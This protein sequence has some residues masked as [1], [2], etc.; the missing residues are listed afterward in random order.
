[1]GGSDDN[2][3]G[4][5]GAGWFVTAACAGAAG[6]STTSRTGSA[7]VGIGGAV[8]IAGSGIFGST[9]G[10]TVATV[11]AGA[12]STLVFGGFLTTGRGGV[13]R[14]RG[15]WTGRVGRARGGRPRRSWT[16]RHVVARLPRM[17]GMVVVIVSQLH[18][19]SVTRAAGLGVRRRRLL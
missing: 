2:G 9:G 10:S 15:H 4:A 16:R 12:G 5:A 11:S 14:G 13:E 8:V 6:T 17:R 1:A 19:V 18:C 7:G 3:A